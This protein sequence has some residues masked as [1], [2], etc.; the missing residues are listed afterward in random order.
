MN[1]TL[2]H[3]MAQMALLYEMSA[4][5][6]DAQDLCSLSCAMAAVG[7]LALEASRA[8]TPGYVP[9]SWAGGEKPKRKEEREKMANMASFPHFQLVGEIYEARSIE[10]AAKKINEEGFV[11]IFVNEEAEAIGSHLFCLGKL[12]LSRM[13]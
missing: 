1:E 3:L 11:M 9:A 13:K 5:C 12:D 2:K 4:K 7:R 10:E 6:D 8:D